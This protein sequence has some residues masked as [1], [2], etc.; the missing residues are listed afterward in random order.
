MP[1]PGLLMPVLIISP[2][3]APTGSAI[4]RHYRR[5]TPPAVQTVSAGTV[6]VILRPRAVSAQATAAAMV[7]AILEKQALIA[8]ATT[9]AIPLLLAEKVMAVNI[10]AL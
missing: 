2:A 9:A 8:P 3:I 7:F 6:S 10:A 1:V 4:T 5:T